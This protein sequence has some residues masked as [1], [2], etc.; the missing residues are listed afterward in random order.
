MYPNE[1]Y[2]FVLSP[3]DKKLDSIHR[4]NSSCF[5]DKLWF[6]TKRRLQML[7]S[8]NQCI[9]IVYPNE[10]YPF[11]LGPHE[12]KLDSIH[13]WNSSYFKDKFWFLTKQTL[14]MLFSRNQRI[15]IVYPNENYPFVWAPHE[16][17]LHSI[18]WRSSSRFK[19]ILWFQKKQRIQMLFRKTNMSIVYPNK[20]LPICLGPSQ[21]QI[22]FYPRIKFVPF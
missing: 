19:E 7:F 1:N 8:R 6:Q 5:K 22:R 21:K 3:R 17:K 16:K 4:R 13:G 18:H 11:V 12:N 9:N 10:N 14:K 2:P 20:K 15:N